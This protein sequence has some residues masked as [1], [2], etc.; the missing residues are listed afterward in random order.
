MQWPTCLEVSPMYSTVICII[1]WSIFSSGRMIG[2]M[3]DG[4]L[5]PLGLLYWER[6]RCFGFDPFMVLQPSFVNHVCLHCRG[7]SKGQ[8]PPG[9]M[10][11]WYAA[12]LF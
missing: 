4:L 12:N 7:K 8:S 9:I 5:S 6:V 3:L 10:H 11:E 1:C 2:A